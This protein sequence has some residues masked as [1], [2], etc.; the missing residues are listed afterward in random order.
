MEKKTL[1]LNPGA[2]RIGTKPQNTPAAMGLRGG[3]AVVVEGIPKRRVA[4]VKPPAS[5][6]AIK[7]RPEAAAPAETEETSAAR[8]LRKREAVKAEDDRQRIEEEKREREYRR[9]AEER[10]QQEELARAQQEQAAASGQVERPAD[11][12]PVDTADKPASRVPA[13]APRPGDPARPSVARKTDRRRGRERDT[14]EQKTQG[15]SFQERRNRGKLNIARVLNEDDFQHRSHAAFLRSQERK[16]RRAMSSVQSFEKIVREVQLPETIVVQ[17]LANRMAERVADVVKTL[18]RNGIMATQNQSIDADTAELIV[19]EFGHRT[20]RVSDADVEDVIE[21]VDDRPEDLQ[22]RPPVV[23]VM[24]HV[25]HGKTS[26]LDAIRNTKVVDGEAGGITQHIGAYQVTL[27]TGARITFLDTPG[28]E[29]FTAMRA[30]GAQVTDIVVLVVA[31]D[32]AVMPQTVEAINHARAAEVPVIVAINKCDLPGA[33]PDHVRNELLRSGIVVEKRSGDVLDVELSAVTGAGID[34]LLD[35]IQLQAELLEL[36]ANPD[37]VA[38]G[39]VVEAKLATGAGTVATILVRHGTLRVGN[40]FVV[41]NQHG[42]V[43]AMFD[44][45][46][47]KVEEATPSMPVEVLGLN[48]APQAGDILN[49]VENASQAREIAEYRQSLNRK[50]RAAAGASASL[51]QLRMIQEGRAES[52]VSELRLVVKTDVQGS[53][54]AIVQAVER[55]GNEEVKVRVLHSGVGAISETDISLA[56]ASSAIVIGF[57]IRPSQMS[58]SLAEKT[59]VP[60]RNYRIIYDLIDDIRKLASN[61]LEAEFKETIIGS[62]DVLEIFN[63]TGVGTVAGCRVSDGSVRKSAGVRLLR[64]SVVVHE[65]RLKSLK[66][67]KDEVAEVRGGQECGMAFE[68]YGDIKPG[69]RIEIYEREEI[70]RSL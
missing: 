38:E 28:H 47:E 56:E 68:N 40:F 44:E 19:E 23:S 50:K 63:I 29:A 3:N 22:P 55:I 34:Q 21:T 43:R 6:P 1:S 5:K 16:K 41:G 36:N 48:G 27:K 25:D 14:P 11:L 13:P 65:G 17:E 32:D 7:P 30:R 60:I 12:A 54:E 31:A 66:R 42:K 59:G 8:Q 39:T 64:D 2:R 51:E 37:R 52:A 70:E 9:L 18:V 53:A 67:F 62:A 61:L 57:N 10:R 45:N 4:A 15:R 46:R 35:A 33:D 49:V 24:G 69:D 20:V 58:M 26:L